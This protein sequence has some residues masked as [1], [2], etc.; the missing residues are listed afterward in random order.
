MNQRIFSLGIR[1]AV[2]LLLCQALAADAAPP[3][4][5]IAKLEVY[6]RTITLDSARHSTSLIVTAIDESGQ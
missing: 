6:P 1:L 5:S 3:L 2:C 4:K